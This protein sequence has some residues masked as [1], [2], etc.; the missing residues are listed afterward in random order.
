MNAAQPGETRRS[1]LVQLA[2]ITL[3]TFLLPFP[4]SAE[5]KQVADW[6][7]TDLQMPQLLELVGTPTWLL[8]KGEEDGDGDYPGL[9]FFVSGQGAQFIYA[10]EAGRDSDDYRELRRFYESTLNPGCPQIDPHTIFPIRRTPE[11]L[12]CIRNR[13]LHQDSWDPIFA[14]ANYL[15]SQG[16]E[17]GDY[18]EADALTLSMSGDD[19]RWD[20]MCQRE[21]TMRD[22]MHRRLLEPLG[23]LGIWPTVGTMF[24]PT[25]W[26]NFGIVETAVV[27]VHGILPDRIDW[28][29]QAAPGL[30]E[31]TIDFDDWDLPAIISRPQMSQIVELT[32]GHGLDRHVTAADMAAISQSK[33][34]GRLRSLNLSFNKI[35]AGLDSLSDSALLGQLEVLNLQ[36]CAIPP[37]A[38]SKFFASRRTGKL[39]SLNMKGNGVTAEAL[40]Q[41]PPGDWSSLAT[42]ELGDSEFGLAGLQHVLA[43]D[44][45]ALTALELDQCKLDDAAF[46]LLADWPGLAQLERLNVSNNPITDEGLGALAKS[47]KLAN[48]QTL[49]IS[50]LPCSGDAIASLLE[51]EELQDLSELT[52]FTCYGA[53]IDSDSAARI[54]R[55]AALKNLETF[56]IG[57]VEEPGKQMLIDE[58]D[59]RISFVT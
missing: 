39:T 26:L 31:L 55:S 6:C 30:S 27:N 18:I 40:E 21:F 43:T 44:L 41:F 28:L 36:S 59:D 37:E 19:P 56:T 48:L 38:Q 33:T 10:R 24:A 29:F 17:L 5:T 34:L 13:M 4:R 45:E 8:C 50:H 11:E 42:L 58:F 22:R 25:M 53:K 23:A 51:L 12:A 2:G 54:A 57:D 52:C 47:G 46:Q 35:E 3:G 15:K 32:F 7:S 14:Y 1:F 20:E 16:D 49:N 9:L